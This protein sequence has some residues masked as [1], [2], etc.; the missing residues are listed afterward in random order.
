MSQPR[1]NLPLVSESRGLRSVQDLQL[2]PC[3]RTVPDRAG[4]L[5]PRDRR[6]AYDAMVREL[7]HHYKIAVRK[8]RTH[9]TGVA[10]ELKYHDGRIRRFITA[11]RPRSPVS[12]A[13]FLHEVGH[14]AVGFHRYKPRAL[15]EYYAWQ[16]ALREMTARNIPITTAVLRHYRRSM[17]HYVRLERK[18]GITLDHLPHDLRQ[19][20]HCPAHVL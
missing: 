15:E 16:W 2:P 18:R 9:M 8:W 13:I 14:H 19:F 5:T 20:L 12:A 6:A 10:Y 11:P 3:R 7:K 1:H 4:P 17:F